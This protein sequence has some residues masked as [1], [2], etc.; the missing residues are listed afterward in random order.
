M[1]L[2]VVYLSLCVQ[3]VPADFCKF[4]EWLSESVR[5]DH[6]YLL[7]VEERDIL[8]CLDFRN[9]E[10]CR[11]TSVRGSVVPGVMTP[12]ATCSPHGIAPPTMH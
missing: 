9:R 8:P 12:G 11:V 7:Q 4:R 1:C 2:P 5:D 3:M 10:V 6:P